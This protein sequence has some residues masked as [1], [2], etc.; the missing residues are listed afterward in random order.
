MLVIVGL[1]V[2][3]V[4]GI[5][6]ITRELSNAGAAHP[7]TENLRTDTL[8][9]V[10]ILVGA[11]ALLELRVLFS[12]ARRTASRG[13]DAQPP[14]SNVKWRSSTEPATPGS[15]TNSEPTAPRSHRRPDEGATRRRRNPLPGR[16][17]R[18]RQSMNSGRVDEAR[19]RGL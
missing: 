9:L 1:F 5:V 18:D 3:L 13:P 16:W 15:N 6:A 10:G 11:V 12:G 2:W 7:L 4:A 17:S 19:S 8:F 14:A